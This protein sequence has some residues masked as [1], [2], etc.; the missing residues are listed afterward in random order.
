MN[1]LSFSIKTKLR[2][3]T[4]ILKK[5]LVDGIAA[6]III[7]IFISYMNTDSNTIDLNKYIIA[8]TSGYNGSGHVNTSIDWDSIEKK[9]GSRIMFLLI[10]TTV[11]QMVM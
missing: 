2:S 7:I 1:N 6:V 5:Y 11:I 9:Y 10:I 3:L 8:E 4:S